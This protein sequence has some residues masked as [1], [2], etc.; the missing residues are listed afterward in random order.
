MNSLVERN[1]LFKRTM[2]VFFLPRI[3]IDG[4]VQG[5]TLYVEKEENVSE[6]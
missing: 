1:H 3:A 2:S 5:G 6:R 4:K